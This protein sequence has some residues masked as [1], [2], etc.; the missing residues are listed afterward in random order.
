[1]ISRSP[2]GIALAVAPWVVLAS[3]FFLPGYRGV[4]ILVAGVLIVANFAY[5]FWWLRWERSQAQAV[6]DA[7]P[8]QTA[9][10]AGLATREGS[11]RAERARVVAVVADRRGLS[12]RD[13]HDV[14][15]Q[16]LAADRILSIELGPLVPRRARPV[17]IQLIDGAPVELWAGADE[18]RLL[19]T[20]VALRTALGRAAG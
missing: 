10:V 5:T 3:S 17:R 13:R 7:H 4:L 16:H 2:L 12:L 6:V 9:L 1:V 18:N 14:E 20:V 19:D 8:G 11:S 15:V